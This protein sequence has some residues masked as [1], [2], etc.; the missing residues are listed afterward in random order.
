MD[1]G[2]LDRIEQALVRG[3]RLRAQ[4]VPVPQDFTARIMREVRAKASARV[5]FWDVFGRAAR[6]FAPVGALAATG[7]CGY[8][9]VMER[10]LN[11]ALVSLSLHGGSSLTLAGF[12]P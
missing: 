10:V 1:D 12:M 4:S 2:R 11:Q 3:A 5:E 6:R 8:A 9:Q 7:A